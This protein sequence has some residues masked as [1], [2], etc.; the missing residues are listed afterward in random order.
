VGTWFLAVGLKMIENG[1]GEFSF[2]GF[3]ERGRFD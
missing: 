1:G 2:L 3:E